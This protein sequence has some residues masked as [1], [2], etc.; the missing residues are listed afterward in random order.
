[1][2]WK[3]I[4]LRR[5]ILV[6]KQL[7]PKLVNCDEIKAKS[8]ANVLVQ[9]TKT[10][11][12][13]RLM[14]IRPKLWMVKS[15]EIKPDK[16]ERLARNWTGMELNPHQKKRHERENLKVENLIKWS[17]LTQIKSSTNHYWIGGSY[18]FIV[19]LWI[20]GYSLTA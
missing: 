10:I 13:E 3:K 5:K 19:Q 8:K 12:K 6:P 14:K 2:T 15:F 11:Y 4:S 9:N 17:Q 18:P 16:D 20:H 7:H 1:M